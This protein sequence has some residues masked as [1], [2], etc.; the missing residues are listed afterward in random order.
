MLPFYRSHFHIHHY[1]PALHSPRKQLSR[2]C[3]L[4]G[5]QLGQAQMQQD[6]DGGIPFSCTK[7]FT[8]YVVNV[9]GVSPWKLICYVNLRI[10][11]SPTCIN[12]HIFD[13]V[14]LGLFTFSVWQVDFSTQP[15]QP[16][17][18]R[19]SWVRKPTE[20]APSRE[21]IYYSTSQTW[22]CT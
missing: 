11:N 22:P 6:K 8:S 18:F 14:R 10:F 5:R 7:L 9:I 20:L 12:P 16:S 2:V 4:S 1:E 15:H 21:P 3:T 19:R 17:H 13:A